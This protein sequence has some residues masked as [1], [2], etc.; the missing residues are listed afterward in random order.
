MDI[1]VIF[2]DF[3]RVFEKKIDKDYFIKLQFE[4]YNVENGIWQIDVNN[5]NVFI[6][7][8]EK[9]VPEEIFVLSKETLIKMY[10]NEISP[11]TAFLQDINEKGELCSLIEI[12][13][14]T[15]DKRVYL[16]KKPS[17]EYIQFINKLNKFHNFFSKDFPTKIIVK[18]ENGRKYCNA[19]S[20]GLY[21]N[22]GKGIAHIFFSIKKGEILK[23]ECDCS[24][25]VINGKGIIKIDNEEYKIIEK[26]YY[27]I[28]SKDT[29]IYIENHEENNLD[30]LY[31]LNRKI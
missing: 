30:I 3:A 26:E 31:F 20:I 7:N 1:K 19:N 28:N 17:D 15:E 16:N 23:E 27:Q 5:G 29:F 2:N 13:N 21:S 11:L 10:N 9:F 24:I 18:N 12:K 14:K 25:Y 22:F 4:I 6:Y 8:E